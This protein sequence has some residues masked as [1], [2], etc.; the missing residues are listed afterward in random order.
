MRFLSGFPPKP[1]GVTIDGVFH[2]PKS[3]DSLEFLHVQSGMTLIMQISNSNPATTASTNSADASYR[4]KRSHD[5]TEK[6][7]EKRPHAHEAAE[8]ADRKKRRK[9]TFVGDASTPFHQ[10]LF[11]PQQTIFLNRIPFLPDDLPGNSEICTIGLPEMVA[12][13]A[14]LI[15][16]INY[17]FDI[18]WLWE[19]GCPSICHIPHVVIVHGERNER[20]ALTKKDAQ[21]YAARY[22]QTITVIA[23]PLPIPF[24]THH[25]KAMLLFYKDCKV[26]ISIHTANYL[27]KDWWHKTQGVWLQDFPFLPHP[28]PT[29]SA[30]TLAA[31][32][33]PS[34][35]SPSSASSFG[36]YLLA[37]LSHYGPEFERI[38]GPYWQSSTGGAVDFSRASHL[39]LVASVPGYHSSLTASS[40]SMHQSVGDGVKQVWG[41]ARLAWVLQS[42]S[43][44]VCLSKDPSRQY[45]CQYSS[46]GSFN[47]AWL[48]DEFG[49]ALRQVRAAAELS[50]SKSA[51]NAFASLQSGKAFQ[52]TKPSS[53][54]S[55]S[56]SA[57]K[58]SLHLIW[59]DVETI[60]GSLEG[61]A[62]GASIPG[63][64]KNVQK[65]HVA[66]RTFQWDATVSGRVCAPPHIKTYGA[67]RLVPDTQTTDHCQS[68]KPHH[69]NQSPKVVLDWLLLTSANLSGAAWGQRLKSRQG[70]LQIRSYELGIVLWGP[71]TVGYQQVPG[72]VPLPHALPPPRYT[73]GTSKW[74]RDIPQTLEDCHGFTW[75]GTN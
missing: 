58:S 14:D 44:A 63:D 61:W 71:L 16:L 73:A 40:P 23:P 24:G 12:P 35:S 49:A 54:S 6:E 2:P 51:P 8:D 65:Q 10:N 47:A 46:L 1:L 27:A 30:P 60:R 42:K 53:T 11:E 34:S 52:V 13:G 62:A 18:P 50:P 39:E 17:M 69:Q 28:S 5:L 29:V 33:L 68:R 55:S 3:A 20:A 9:Q 45:F 26:R 72:S 19:E 57:G 56:S 21:R 31:D 7:V 64:A 75:G 59:P 67:Y 38:V 41:H 15:V 48:H 22:G 74:C 32:T 36:A 70:Q 43:P 4:F 25:S 66:E 37:Y